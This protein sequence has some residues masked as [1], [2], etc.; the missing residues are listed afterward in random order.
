MVSVDEP[1][2]SMFVR[3]LLQPQGSIMSYLQSNELMW[4]YLN[5]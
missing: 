5:H 1:L 4:S 2:F 3:L